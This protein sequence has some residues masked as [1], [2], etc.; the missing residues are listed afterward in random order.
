MQTIRRHGAQAP[1]KGPEAW[2]TGDVTV[3]M[4]F[5]PTEPSRVSGAQ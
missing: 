3:E 2:F 4:L 1:A 5:T